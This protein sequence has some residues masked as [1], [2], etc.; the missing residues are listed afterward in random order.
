MKKAIVTGA[1]GFIGRF[2]VR[3]LVS[4]G[5]QVIAIVREGTENLSAIKDLPITICACNLDK[6][7]QLPERVVDRDIDAVF[8]LAWQGVSDADARDQDVQLKNLKATLDL[9]DA[10]KV[11]S[12]SCFVGCGSIHEAEALIET[13]EDTPIRNLGYMYKAAKI[14]AH[15]MGKAKAG[16][17][18]IRFFWPLINTYGEEE[19]SA[20]LIN[21]VIR[22]ILQGRSP[23]LSSAEQYYD[24]VHVSDVAH[25]LFL[26]AE[27]GVDGTN[28]VIGSGSAR[29]L[30]EFLL[31]VAAVAN[32]LKGTNVPLNFGK[33]V[34]NVVP[35]P[36]E[37]FDISKL[38]RDTG[39]KPKVSFRDGIE[40]TARW[41]Q[42]DISQK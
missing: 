26:I 17:Y 42:K 1:T 37:V 7:Y 20:R 41:I 5:V 30:K 39:F 8:H 36:K 21:S 23:E 22:N 24:F 27:K 15:W 16:D 28:Y 14:A 38:V 33:I 12:I 29:P 6:L 10:M 3:E 40:R 2:L 13:A 25:A 35:L 31:T 32:G 9:L 34:N 19:R 18:A 11:M 4:Q